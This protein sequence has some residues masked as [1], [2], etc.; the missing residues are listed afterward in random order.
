MGWNITNSTDIESAFRT[1]FANTTS[2]LF[3]IVIGHYQCFRENSMTNIQVLVFMTIYHDAVKCEWEE[4]G[5]R[6]I[7]GWFLDE[8]SALGAVT[9]RLLISS[10]I[11]ST[12]RQLPPMAVSSQYRDEW[13][14]RKVCEFTRATKIKYSA[15]GR[16]I[17]MRPGAFAKPW[18]P[19]IGRA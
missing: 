13:S 3:L 7:I 1:M 2:L 9:E 8:V 18:M 14:K 10:A 12:L 4:Y 6:E 19:L 16:R 17:V 5:R 15:T 11:L